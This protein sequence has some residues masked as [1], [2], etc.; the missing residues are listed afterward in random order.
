M[1]QL[2]IQ[3]FRRNFIMGLR[4]CSCWKA[5][6]VYRRGQ[7]HRVD[8]QPSQNRNGL[9]YNGKLLRSFMYK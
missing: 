9:L 2:G 3:V 7:V 1:Q 5:R 4:L 6:G 8:S